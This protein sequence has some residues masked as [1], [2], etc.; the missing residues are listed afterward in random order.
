[1]KPAVLIAEGD[2]KLCDAYRRCLLGPSYEVETAPDGPACLEKLAR[3]APAV[4]VLG[5]EATQARAAVLGWLRE[6]RARTIIILTGDAPSQAVTQTVLALPG[7][8]A[9]FR[10]PIDPA[11]LGGAVLSALAAARRP[12]APRGRG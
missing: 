12:A 8:V 5:L 2:A 10:K 6:N 7:A 3:L 11:A 9:Y 1:M 4:L